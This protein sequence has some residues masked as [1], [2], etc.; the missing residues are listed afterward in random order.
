MAAYDLSGKFYEACDCEVICS[1]WVGLPPEMGACT[2]LF[3]W[4]IDAGIVNRQ[5]V[6]GSK[7]VVMS[8]G[9]SCDISTY[10][11]VLIDGSH[12]SELEAALL[13][14]GAWHDVFQ[15]QSFA[16]AAQR[17]IQAAKIA[18]HDNGKAIGISIHSIDP[19]IVTKAELN[20]RITSVKIVGE[21]AD[22]PASAQL[23]VD[24]VVGTATDKS[25]T[26]GVVD[27]PIDATQNGLN[28]LAD[29]PGVYTFDLDI[30][31]V[32]AMRGKFHYV[33]S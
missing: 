5:D 26:V 9:K 19:Q 25:I 1:C 29:I 30:S 10:M 13:D 32:T 33:C 14:A 21:N 22:R 31:R 4:Q 8:S 24:R 27:T 7:V 6:C 20:F 18:I 11:L 28:L 17:S 12:Q 3:V 15:A 2:G 16:P 23:L